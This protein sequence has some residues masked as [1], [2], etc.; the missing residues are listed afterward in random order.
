MQLEQGG[1]LAEP[2][3]VTQ[4]TGPFVVV[5]MQEI[6][7][8]DQRPL[9]GLYCFRNAVKDVET[10]SREPETSPESEH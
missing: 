1:K 3:C 7:E 5:A 8:D 6:A 10:S 9:I 2:S 4:N